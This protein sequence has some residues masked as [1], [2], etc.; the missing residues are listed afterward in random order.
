MG[1]KRKEETVDGVVDT[2]GNG[3]SNGKLTIEDLADTV[4]QLAK[5]VQMLT[6][7]GGASEGDA[8]APDDADLRDQAEADAIALTSDTSIAINPLGKDDKKSKASEM[9]VNAMFNTPRE[10]LDEMTNISGN[11]EA[12]AFAGVRTINQFIGKAFSRQAGDPM[13]LMSDLYL[14]NA[15]KLKRSLGGAHLFRAMAMSQVEKEKE[16]ARENNVIFGGMGNE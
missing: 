5:A 2:H 4:S 12:A 7:R 15:E 6:A 3:H 1:R 9:L 11:L 16:E 8:F 10:K 13:I 14:D